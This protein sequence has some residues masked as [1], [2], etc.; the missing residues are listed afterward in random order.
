M[1]GFGEKKDYNVATMQAKPTSEKWADC[2]VAILTADKFQD[3]EFF[4]PYYRFCE[5]GCVVD[6]ITPN[7]GKVESK[8]GESLQETKKISE[9]RATDYELLYIPGGKAPAALAGEP[10]ALEFVKAY[11]R[12]GRTLAVI[13]HGAQVL[14]AAGLAKGRHMAAW[15]DVQ[16]EIE[17]A[18]GVFA[19]QPTEQDGNLISARW[20][21]DLPSHLAAVITALELRRV[22]PKVA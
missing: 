11:D 16:G 6:V 12:T 10:E 13:C 22:R 21:G 9:C 18:G 15:P 14:V 3:M 4:Y 1:F 2:R 5:A 17:E 20:P 19:N 7:G 8:H